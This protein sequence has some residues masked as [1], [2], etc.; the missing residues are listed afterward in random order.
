MASS[1]QEQQRQENIEL[2]E[3]CA[4]QEEQVGCP[5]LHMAPHGSTWLHVAPAVVTR[6]AKSSAAKKADLMAIS[7]NIHRG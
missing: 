3:R 1:S 2:V 5:E 7:L 4:S 6:G